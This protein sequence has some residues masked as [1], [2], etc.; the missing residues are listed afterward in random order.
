MKLSTSSFKANAVRATEDPA[1]RN[2]LKRATTT[3][4]ESRGPTVAETAGWE[5]LRS[6]AAEIK[7]ETVEHLDSYLEQFTENV[8]KNGGS[9]Y[10]AKNGKDAC[11]YV[12]DLARKKG[13]GRIV[14]SKS[15]I[16]EE[17][18]LN[19][20]LQD[21]AVEVTET[22][23][24]EY[25]I[26]LLGDSPSH[27]VAPAI[28]KSKVE[29]A[30]LFADRL[31]MPYT[32]DVPELT[33][34]AR[35][36]LRKKFFEAEMGISGTN[37]GVAETGS[38]VIVENEG[39]ARLTTTLPPIH[40]A[41]M[42]IERLIPK[43][44]DLELFLKLLVRS[45][46]GQKISS[47]VSVITGVSDKVASVGPKEFHLVLVDNGRTRILADPVLR[48]SLY[49]LRCGACLNVCPVYQ[50]VGGHAYGWVYPGPIGAVI[51]PQFVGIDQAR[52]L[53]FASSLCGACREICPVKINLPRLL[54]NLR[55]KVKDG[56]GNATAY[57]PLGENLGMKTFAFLARYPRLFSCVFGVL[58]VFQRPFVKD[59]YLRL[60]RIPGMSAWTRSR[61]LSAL[62]DNNFAT[63][64]KEVSKDDG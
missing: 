13:I 21:A 29:I 42:G 45:A 49:C 20:A 52:D 9:V 47:Y 1:L 43:L 38:I 6:D 34:V 27:V 22:D 25:I 41:V 40:V 64:W 7:K 61:E 39:N 24:G 3:F 15:M 44:G 37:Y 28:H 16:T 56:T 57:R 19:E 2:A 54:L 59:G 18:S 60:R 63:R 26:Q 30:E 48:E 53:P 23:L 8:E 36:V 35:E 5:R 55:G 17:I 14:K 58:R 62:A 31:G 12:V 51:T 32:E 46:S 33:K 11:D 50:K 10:W 4:L